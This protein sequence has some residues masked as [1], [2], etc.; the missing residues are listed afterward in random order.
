MRLYEEFVCFESWSYE[1]VRRRTVQP[2]GI[3]MTI[4]MNSELSIPDL[5]ANVQCFVNGVPTILPTGRLS[6]DM[7]LPDTCDVNLRLVTSEPFVLFEYSF[8]PARDDAEMLI[9]SGYFRTNAPR[10]KLYR[11]TK[12]SMHEYMSSRTELTLGY[13]PF[14]A[15]ILLRY[16]NITSLK[17]EVFRPSV[18]DWAAFQSIVRDMTWLEELSVH[19]MLEGLEPYVFELFEGLP[20]KFSI[21]GKVTMVALER[22]RNVRNLTL[23]MSGQY[24]SPISTELSPHLQNL[25]SLNCI[26]GVL[27]FDLRT[28]MSLQTL[29][30]DRVRFAYS[31]CVAIGR[32]L[33]RNQLQSLELTDCEWF[34]KNE[35]RP[36]VQPLLDGSNTSLY[37]MGLRGIRMSKHMIY[38]LQ[39]VITFCPTLTSLYTDESPDLLHVCETRRGLFEDVRNIRITKKHV[40]ERSVLRRVLELTESV[41]LGLAPYFPT[42]RRR[43][44]RWH[45]TGERA[46]VCAPFEFHVSKIIIM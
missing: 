30:L 31:D 23:D 28:L 15:D 1:Y 20:T 16:P 40:P 26:F 7:N 21:R 6:F 19:V 22:L 38:M 10:F 12:S 33:R 25:T 17:I 29:K 44:R 4:D 13:R 3:E 32:L 27:Q 37:H 24:E 36:I 14:S 41:L 42:Y 11:R 46:L 5:H 34:R 35:L 8:V 45:R 9:D 2:P 43:N 18:F 39:D